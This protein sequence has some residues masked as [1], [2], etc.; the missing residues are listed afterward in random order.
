LEGDP[1]APD[2][3]QGDNTRYPPQGSLLLSDSA[4]EKS[5]LY[6]EL[7]FMN[8]SFLRVYNRKKRREPLR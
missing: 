6:I 8:W 2:E 7:L 5:N 4:K 1:A 3:R